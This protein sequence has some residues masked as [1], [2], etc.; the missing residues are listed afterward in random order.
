MSAMAN[1]LT[2]ARPAWYA[3]FE[4]SLDIMRDDPDGAA[5]LIRE[6]KTSE[7]ADDT[8]PL[9]VELV[10][11]LCDFFGDRITDDGTAFLKLDARFSARDLRDGVLLS[12]FGRAAVLRTRGH[13]ADAYHYAHEHILPFISPTS[14]LPSVLSLNLMG[15]VAQEFGRTDEAIRHF[16]GAMEA[17]KALGLI[18]REAQ[19]TCNLGELFFIWGNAEDGETLLLRARELAIASQEQWLQPFVCTIMALCKLSRGETDAAYEAIAPFLDDGVAQIGRA[20]SNRGFLLAIAAYT[21]AQRGELD[22]AEAHCENA[23]V[24]AGHYKENYLRPY[25]WWARGHLYH[26]RGRIDEA[27][28][29]LNRALDEIG[30]VGYTFMPMRAALE[31]ADIHAERGDWQASLAAYKRHHALFERSQRQSTQT[32]LQVLQIHSELREAEAARRHAEEA[33][34][35][36]SMFL[37]NMSHEIR[38]PMNAII[39]MAHLALKTP[40]SPKQRDYVEKIHNAGV[41]L[42]GVINDILDFSKIEAGKLDVETVDFDLDEVLANVSAVTAGRAYEKGLDFQFDIPAQVPRHLRGDPLRLGQILINLLNNAV[43]FTDEGSVLLTAKVDNHSDS[44]VTLAFAV[45]DT[46]IGMAQEQTARLFQA[47]TQVDG[48][49]TRRFGGT[50][51]GL[52]ISRKLVEMMGG[53]ISVDSAPSHGSTFRFTVRLLR[54]ALPAPMRSAAEPQAPTVMP[55]FSGVRVL[56][57][58]DN[59]INQQI[60]VELLQAAGVEVDTAGD[61]RE[62]LDRL[63]APDAL[64]YDL[65]LLDVQMPIMDGYA[66]I[67]AIRAERRFADLPVVAMTAHALIEERERCISSGMNDH[68]AKPISPHLLFETVARWT[69]YRPDT[70]LSKQP[71]HDAH[72][73]AID[74]LDV[75][76]GLARTLGDHAL[77]YDLLT[78]FADEQRA[79]MPRL[80]LAVTTDRNLARRIAHTL[81]S[82]AGLIGASVIQDLAGEIEAITDRADASCPPSHLDALEAELDHMIASIDDFNAASAEVAA[83]DLDLTMLLELLRSHDGE[84]LDYFNQ[85]RDK[86]LAIIPPHVLQQV[87][88]KIR[89]YDYDSA[90]SLI[91]VHARPTRE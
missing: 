82:V 62:A 54:G 83:S 21:L 35:A 49:N 47:F 69:V 64:G 77:Y 33:T 90:L 85:H 23:V 40:L 1:M 58:E 37:A 74:G 27:I 65:V 6:M 8:T 44:H 53:Q 12:R 9:Y 31:L 34:R 39:G 42:L 52:S 18:S 78:R 57:V 75:D 50:G 20:P 89:Q 56:L 13:I 26:R 4:Q 10:E 3:I 60:A 61:G 45:Q 48:T 22:R 66:A 2:P 80:R 32:R 19:I 41:S 55:N 73:P 67:R 11:T 7:H 15:I 71:V 81:K 25:T 28:V 5:E 36:K 17:A 72:L 88:R 16:Y 91:N 51:L 30:E 24:E 59:E 84:A 87:D 63:L 29:D 79:V 46:G 14:E 43:K 86:L 38:T 68:L 70:Q 76:S